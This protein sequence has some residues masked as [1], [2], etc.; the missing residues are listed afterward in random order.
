LTPEDF[1]RLLLK[2]VEEVE[3][4][5]EVHLYGVP[6][7]RQDGQDGIG[8]DPAERPIGFQAKRYLVFAARDLANAV[9]AYTSGRRRMRVVRLL[10]GVATEVRRTEVLDELAAQW[11]NHPELEIE[12]Y[13]RRRL[14]NLLR[15]R[16]DIVRRFLEM[17]LPS[18][19][20]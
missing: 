9:D 6:G 2:L 1:E 16:P 5:R 18:G 10:I 19:S 4:L 17:L 8:F 13:D 7:Q 12:L 11:A 15:D 14:S 20:A 3:G